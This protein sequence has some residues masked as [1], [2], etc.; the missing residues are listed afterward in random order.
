[1]IVVLVLKKIMFFSCFFLF[2]I[3]VNHT[4]QLLKSRLLVR[5]E[6]RDHVDQ[7]LVEALEEP[8][9]APPPAWKGPVYSDSLS[10][11]IG[12]AGNPGATL[13][14]PGTPGFPPAYHGPSPGPPSTPGGGPAPPPPLVPCGPG[15]GPHGFVSSPSGNSGSSTPG[16][17]GMGPVGPVVSAAAHPMN[18]GPN[19]FLP[20]SS[21]CGP[22]PMSGPGQGPMGG[23]Q[24][25]PG[26]GPG[27]PQFNGLGP[28]GPGMPNSPSNCGPPP[29]HYRGQSPP[30]RPG[31]S[32]PPFPFGPG[33]NGPCGP[34]GPPPCGP[35]GPGPHGPHHQ[36]LGPGPPGPHNFGPHGP[37]PGFGPPPHGPMGPHGPMHGPP[38]HFMDRSILNIFKTNNHH[39]QICLF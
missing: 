6:R 1:M 16:P 39:F 12:S 20:P 3:N 14:G 13:P 21:N 7:H 36:F 18:C 19:N 32:G 15:S 28:C 10:S 8:G 17:C 4:D 24:F 22:G 9:P 2:Q 11:S 31:S 38:P 35:P 23:P 25:G 26:P 5:E 29:S 34:N 27:P 33:P 30:G 37:G